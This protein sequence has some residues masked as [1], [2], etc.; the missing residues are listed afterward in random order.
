MGIFFSTIIVGFHR[1]GFKDIRHF[2]EHSAQG[3]VQ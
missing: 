3:M 2:M 1:F